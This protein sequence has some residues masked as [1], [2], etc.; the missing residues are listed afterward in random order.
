MPRTLLLWS[1]FLAL[2]AMSLPAAASDPVVPIEKL[3]VTI[4]STMVVDYI[5]DNEAI[6]EWGFAAL[7]EADGRK[8]LFDTGAHPETVLHNARALGIDLSDVTDVVLS[9]FHADHTSGLVTLR[10]ELRKQNPHA[11][12][13]AHIG[14]GFFWLR[15]EDGKSD[16]RQRRMGDAYRA[17]GGR[18]VEHSQAEQLFPG[19]WVT[20]GV[21]RHTDERNFGKGSEV[22]R[23][24]GTWVEDTVPDDMSLVI[25]TSQGPVLIVG[26]GH[27]GI[28]NTLMA[29]SRTVSAS[30]VDAVIGGL[31]L[32]EA[33][34]EHV[35]WTAQQ[36]RRFGVRHLI[37]A[38]CT[39]IE[40]L[41][42]L[43]TGIGLNRKTAIQGA[44]GTRYTLDQGIDPGPGSLV[45]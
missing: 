18:F 27:A 12:E 36:M 8:I 4:L 37:G 33:T 22:Q 3:R 26:C 14:P 34:D 42:R 15:R 10:Q 16:D 1:L 44:I 43:R 35:D 30:P 13:R 6:G 31:H 11:M 40:A 45:R 20:G 24:D 19:I 39:G 28:V 41:T 23:P 29:V 5:G 32:F 2:T 17:L 38:H 9:H 21:P 25:V 7:V